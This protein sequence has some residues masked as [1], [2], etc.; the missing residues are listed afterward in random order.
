MPL[1][2][3]LISEPLVLEGFSALREAG[4]RDERKGGVFDPRT[5]IRKYDA[6]ADSAATAANPIE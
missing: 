4:S 1:G 6:N 2:S 5:V 3:A